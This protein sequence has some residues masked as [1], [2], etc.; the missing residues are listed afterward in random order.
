MRHSQNR[1]YFFKMKYGINRRKEY[2]YTRCLTS[3]G[4]KNFENA[5]PEYLSRLLRLVG[6]IQQDF[7]KYNKVSGEEGDLEKKL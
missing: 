4:R 2:G 5:S 7:I 6:E 1:F 3:I